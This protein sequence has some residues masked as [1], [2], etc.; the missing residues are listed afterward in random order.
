MPSKSSFWFSFP[1]KSFERGD[2]SNDETRRVLPSFLV[3]RIRYCGIPDLEM[4]HVNNIT[5]H[6]R[7]LCCYSRSKEVSTVV[8]WLSAQVQHFSLHSRISP[9]IFLTFLQV[10]FYQTGLAFNM[11][12]ETSN[13]NGQGAASRKMIY[14][15]TKA[16][17]TEVEITEDRGS[18]REM[19]S[20]VPPAPLNHTAAP[21]LDTATHSRFTALPNELGIK[22]WLLSLPTRI[23][24]IEST[25]SGEVRFNPGG[26]IHAFQVN[27]KSRMQALRAY[28][29]IRFQKVDWNPFYFSPEIDILLVKDAAALN[30]WHKHINEFV[31]SPPWRAFR[32]SVAS[33]AIAPYCNANLP[34]SRIKLVENW[35]SSFES[36]GEDL[37][38][39]LKDYP[40]LK[41]IMLLSSEA[42]R[43]YMKRFK[44]RV[45]RGRRDREVEDGTGRLLPDN[46]IEPRGKERLKSS[47]QLIGGEQMPKI[48]FLTYRLE[49][50]ET[51]MS[52]M[53]RAI[54]RY[55]P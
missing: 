21:T 31:V 19:A 4:E 6:P 40:N 32:E 37:L 29:L 38:N 20:A 53:K 5:L 25:D 34:I 7:Q 22:I 52:A 50:G 10:S 43:D 26:A 16:M 33:L 55:R 44:T 8:C 11:P 45:L 18:I 2:E 24:E 1:V 23:I 12:Q 13:V 9:T 36:L 39:D 30:D 28:S 46:D 54:L 17:G 51:L 48:N 27:R 47:P 41:E 42:N 3:S 49:G 35:M 15:V 14:P